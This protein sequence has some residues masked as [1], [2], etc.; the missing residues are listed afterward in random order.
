[1]QSYP[2]IRLFV[3]HRLSDG[4]LLLVE[5]DPAHYLSRV[6]RVKTGDALALFNGQDGE[7]RAVVGDVGK[8][9]LQLEVEQRLRPFL[10]SPDVWLCFAPIRSEEHTSELQSQR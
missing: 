5:G 4:A 10:P 9:T 1:M 2:K 3:E 7:W 8:R 6:M